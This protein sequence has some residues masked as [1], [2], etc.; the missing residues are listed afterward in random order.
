VETWKCDR[1]KLAAKG[2][3]DADA[4]LTLAHCCEDILKGGANLMGM[5]E[6]IHKRHLKYG[7]IPVSLGR[8][9]V[10]LTRRL[11]QGGKPVCHP[12]CFRIYAL[13]YNEYIYRSGG[14]PQVYP[15]MASTEWPDRRSVGKYDDVLL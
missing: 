6:A 15:Y 3:S 8:F 4:E 14:M 10:L 11:V 1:A 13:N 5:S 7:K 2:Y 9:P 12:E